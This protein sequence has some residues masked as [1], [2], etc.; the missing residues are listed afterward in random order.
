MGFEEVLA[1]PRGGVVAAAGA[2]V[3]AYLGLRTWRTQLRGAAE[4][5]SGAQMVP[6]T[7][8]SDL[9]CAVAAESLAARP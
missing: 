5:E 9:R 3:V 8:S 4:W 2:V 6:A 1:V 7:R